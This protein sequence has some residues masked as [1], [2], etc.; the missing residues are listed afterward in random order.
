MTKH[1][2]MA[3]KELLKG[4]ELDNVPRL[5][6]TPEL[7]RRLRLLEDHLDAPNNGFVPVGKVR[8]ILNGRKP[9]K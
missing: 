6:N 4:A 8:E 9:P 2:D 5:E 1:E 3:L 7:V